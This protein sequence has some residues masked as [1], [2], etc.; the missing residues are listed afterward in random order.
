MARDILSGYGPDRAPMPK[1]SAVAGG[2]TTA[3]PIR[4]SPPTGPKN[5]GNRGPGLGGS[6]YGPCGSQG[7]YSEDC[8]T[9]GS[10]GI[11]GTTQ[12][13]GSQRG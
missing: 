11:G 1:A 7:S 2:V 8:D 10:P 5:L 12:S 9:S 4:Y 6:N 3:K 13:G